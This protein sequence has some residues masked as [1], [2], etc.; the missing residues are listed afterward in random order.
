MTTSVTITGS[1]T[2]ILAPGRAGPGTLIRHDDTLVQVDAGRATTLRLAEAG[3]SAL[4]DIDAVL[5]TH[6]HSDHVLGLTDLFLTRWVHNGPR[7]YDPPTVHCPVGGAVD[8]LEH[9]FDHLR[10]D[11]ES[12]RGVSGYPDDP[13]PRIVPFEAPPTGVVRVLDVGAI[14]IDATVVDHGDLAPAVAYR[15]TTPD[16]V[17][18]VSGDTC[19]CSAVEELA[20]GADVLVHEVFAGGLLTTRGTPPAIIER[21]AHHHTE[22]ALLGAMAARLD[23][24]TLV[25]THMVPSPANDDDRAFFEHAIRDAG[26]TG[27][28]TIANDLHTTTI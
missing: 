18:V 8:Y 22:A 25:A 24:P 14:S 17:V 1:G 7:P 6:H 28:L 3:V 27:D 15:F 16:G 11:I 26:F 9:L 19:A 4:T 23:T 13:H 10:P 2:P 5:V 20:K 21:L 12:R